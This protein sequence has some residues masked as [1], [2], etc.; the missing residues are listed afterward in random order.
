[1]ADQQPSSDIE[2]AATTKTSKHP[3]SCVRRSLYSIA[4]LLAVTSVMG[5]TVAIAHAIT[6]QP[7]SI[8]PTILPKK[9]A[10]MMTLVEVDLPGVTAGSRTVRAAVDLTTPSWH[11]VGGPVAGLC[12]H[13]LHTGTGLRYMFTST[14]CT[15]APTAPAEC[16][17]HR[18]DDPAFSA[19]ARAEFS[20]T[21][22]LGKNAT[23]MSDTTTITTLTPFA[24][25]AVCK[26]KHLASNA[27]TSVAPHVSAAH[28]LRDLLETRLA[29]EM[30]TDLHDVLRSDLLIAA[31]ADAEDDPSI[32]A[33]DSAEAIIGGSLI[34]LGSFWN[35]YSFLVSIH[36]EQTTYREWDDWG[37]EIPWEK[38]FGVEVVQTCGGTL[39]SPDWVLTAAH[40]VVDQSFGGTRDPVK[41]IR[42][43]MWSTS[44][45]SHYAAIF[46]K[47]GIGAATRTPVKIIVHP[48][49][50]AAASWA[51][52]IALVKLNAPVARGG[53]KSS[54][55]IQFFDSPVA[56][57]PVNTQL[58][59]AGWGNTAPHGHGST[60]VPRHVNVP[61]VTCPAA[62]NPTDRAGEGDL[63]AG[64]LGLSSSNRDSGSPLT[65]TWPGT[66]TKV[67]VGVAS[68]G[69]NANHGGGMPSI[70]TGVGYH[71]SWITK[72]MREH[73]CE[74]GYFLLEKKPLGRSGEGDKCIR[75]GGFNHE[76]R[77]PA[78]CQA[79]S[80]GTSQSCLVSSP[81][82]ACRVCII[83]GPNI[84]ASQCGSQTTIGLPGTESW[85]QGWHP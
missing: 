36:G 13:I 67:L 47:W 46:A 12:S 16:S 63:C 75:N 7:S 71:R 40:C 80:G 85:V 30:P 68:R 27:T 11:F 76:W 20:M 73:S 66:N 62:S 60:N 55:W 83:D 82:E 34:P 15:F 43:G 10:L 70:Y 26:E 22:L 19:A 54:P 4:S 65:A 51:H 9:V 81:T 35:D 44:W 37:N 48:S 58:T 3:S 78:G 29:T 25:P 59:V 5:V 41:E 61:Y 52:D 17:F 21:A 33:D 77:H 32:G 28:S 23:T 2:A 8:P 14:E 72:T 31:L 42:I 39:V 84:L 74:D 1:M 45:A 50:S 69:F 24:P 49:Y 56:V 57:R 64:A 53:F 6:H 18:V 38:R 79:C